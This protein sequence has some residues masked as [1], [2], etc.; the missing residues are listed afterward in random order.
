MTGM[1]FVRTFRMKSVRQYATLWLLIGMLAGHTAHTAGGPVPTVVHDGD[2]FSLRAEGRRTAGGKRVA[3]TVVGAGGCHCN[4]DYP[5]KLKVLSIDGGTVGKTVF[6]P[7]DAEP[8]T[9]E[10][11]RFAIPVQAEGEVRLSFE[12]RFSMCNDTQCFMKT[13][14]INMVL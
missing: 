3:V 4:T 8:W 13:V 1:F 12:L 5:W 6:G 2:V 9:F 11:V 7:D 10:K 14:P